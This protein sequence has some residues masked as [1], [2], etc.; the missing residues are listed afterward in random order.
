M[1]HTTAANLATHFGVHGRVI[2]T[3]AACVRANQALGHGFEASG[4]GLPDVML[5]GGAEELHFTHAA[6]FD[7]LHAASKAFNATPE[8]TPRPFDQPRDGLVCGEGA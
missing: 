1:S 7:I 8:L 2:C 6:V 3:S 4:G 5:C